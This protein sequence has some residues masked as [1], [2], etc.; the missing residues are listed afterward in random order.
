MLFESN[1]EQIRRYFCDVWRKH[2][3]GQPLEPL[4]RLIADTVAEH[5]EYQSLLGNPDRALSRDY[6]VEAGETNPFLHMGM[7][8][9]LQEQL[10]SNRPNGI[11]EVYRSLCQ[12]FGSKH[13]AE[14]EMMECLGEMLWETQRS[15]SLPDEAL[16]L[17]R[18]RA[19]TRRQ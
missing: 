3:K 9:A 19:L 1:R 5:P 17:Q 4:E 10:L 2:Q 16:Y 8:I 6:G 13:E 11:L 15:G 7:H 14:H 18:L 12:R